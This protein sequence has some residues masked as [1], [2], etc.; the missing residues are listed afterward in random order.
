MSIEKTDMEGNQA[1]NM[2]NLLKVLGSKKATEALMEIGKTRPSTWT[3]ISDS[4]VG[5][6]DF[7]A[8][9]GAKSIIE[10]FKET[11]DL[12]ITAALTPFKNEIDQL[13][14]DALN[15]IKEIV[16]DI[17]NE[18]STFVSENKVGAAI[19]GIAGQIASLFLPGGPLLV[20]MGALIGAAVEEI[21]RGF[22]EFFTPGGG[23]ETFWDELWRNI[24]GDPKPDLTGGDRYAAPGWDPPGYY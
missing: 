9:G 3:E 1:T 8:A 13:I 16:T 2:S 14:V 21:I 24:F 19:G 23:S 6:N 10:G 4:V 15:P 18:L 7:V 22:I 11:V 20:A 17:F 12:Q 5:L